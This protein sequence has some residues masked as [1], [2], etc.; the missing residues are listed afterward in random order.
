MRSPEWMVSG[1]I[2]AHL[3]RCGPGLAMSLPG[4]EDQY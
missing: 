3:S 2:I 4:T 1:T